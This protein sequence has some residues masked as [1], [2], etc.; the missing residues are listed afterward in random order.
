MSSR[1][2][3]AK[4]GQ[5]DLKKGASYKPGTLG[6]DPKLITKLF[7]RHVSSDNPLFDTS[8][9][10]D[11][12]DIITTHAQE[13]F[14]PRQFLDAVVAEASIGPG[15]SSFSYLD[16]FLSPVVQALYTLE[17][18]SFE[19]DLSLCE[20]GD[21]TL[22]LATALKGKPG[23]L[24]EM[25]YTGI[26]TFRFG[27]SNEFCKLTLEGAAES[28]G[29]ESEWSEFIV[30]KRVP[31]YPLGFAGSNCTFRLAEIDYCDQMFLDYLDH[32]TDEEYGDALAHGPVLVYIKNKGFFERGNKL[33]VPDSQD[34]WKE[35]KLL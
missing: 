9:S 18:N 20:A 8:L 1:I 19:L 30:T 6:Y 13:D 25:K 26:S 24:L 14:D 29:S 34:E 32:I 12:A 35:V 28:V 11:F 23:R 16:K 33:Y 22:N 5:D 2:F 31:L 27:N 21:R 3:K 7:L 4:L 10:E 15:L 17:Y